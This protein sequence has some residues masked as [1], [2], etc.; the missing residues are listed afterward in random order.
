MAVCAI[1]TF[2]P[3]I[4]CTASRAGLRKLARYSISPI[5][6]LARLT[7]T[8]FSAAKAAIKGW[9]VRVKSYCAHAVALS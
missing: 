6:S 8:W 7:E 1:G 3:T 2:E 9:A 5:S 4:S